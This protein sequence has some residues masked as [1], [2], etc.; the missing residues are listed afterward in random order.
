[1]VILP[2]WRDE[3]LRDITHERIQEWVT[4]LS[5][6]PAARQY[7]KKSNADAGLSPARVI[8]SHQVVRQVMAYAVR[9]KYLATNP[10]EHIELPSKS[11]SK[12]LALTHDQVCQ[13]A[14]ASGEVATMVRFLAYTGLRYGEC[15][16]LRWPTSTPSTT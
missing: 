1:M 12:D 6:D 3:R 2:K 10:A 13:L 8:Q 11:R 16:T 9:S 5:T 4:W 15:A 14:A 7:K